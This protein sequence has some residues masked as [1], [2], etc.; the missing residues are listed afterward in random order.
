MKNEEHTPRKGFL[1][2]YYG[3]GPGK[4]SAVIG[5][6]IRALG[7][8]KKP[9]VFQFL[10]KH[11]PTN[12][13]GF[14]YGEYVTLTEMLHIPVVQCGLTKFIHNESEITAELREETAKVIKQIEETVRTDLYD[15]I[16]LDEIG[17]AI[18][19]NLVSCAEVVQL[20]T[21]RKTAAEIMMTSHN[22]I[23]EIG[24]LCD[25]V[26][27]MKEQKHPYQKGVLA[28]AGIEY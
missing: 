20:L 9:V 25:Y 13:Q 4:T 8:H 11:D 21:T 12:R 7:W 2:F 15:L 28:R 19:L 18:E 24:D 14:F 3:T 10:K 17:S 1:H 6:T 22:F 16:I 26:V 5:R 23:P 27:E